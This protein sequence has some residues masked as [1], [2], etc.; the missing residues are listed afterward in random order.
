MKRGD[1]EWQWVWVVLK[2]GIKGDGSCG[3]SISPT[4]SMLSST[5]GWATCSKQY[6]LVPYDQ[7]V[8][9]VKRRKALVGWTNGLMV[10]SWSHS[11]TGFQNTSGFE[12]KGS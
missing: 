8:D 4:V 10:G 1:H 9:G 11:T 7:V 3:R 2:T 5:N 6:G 12:C